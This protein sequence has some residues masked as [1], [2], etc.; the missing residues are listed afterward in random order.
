MPGMISY[1]DSPD[2]LVQIMQRVS[3]G[4]PVESKCPV[5][6]QPL[7]I[8]ATPQRAAELDLH[9]GIYCPTSSRHVFRM[10]ELRTVE[11][12]AGAWLDKYRRDAAGPENSN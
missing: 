6:G 2:F 8:V 5:C 1:S 7:L 9:P 12:N 11:S 10:I 3:K 4:E